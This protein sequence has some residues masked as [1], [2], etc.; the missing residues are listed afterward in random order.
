MTMSPNYFWRFFFTEFCR[1]WIQFFFPCS[2]NT[3][4]DR[5]ALCLWLFLVLLSSRHDK[6]ATTRVVVPHLSGSF[7]SWAV[8]KNMNMNETDQNLFNLFRQETCRRW[9][10]NKKPTKP[11][12]MQLS[13]KEND[14]KTSRDSTCFVLF[15]WLCA[16]RCF[17]NGGGHTRVTLDHGYFFGANFLCFTTVS[18]CTSA[19]GTVWFRGGFYCCCRCCWTINERRIDR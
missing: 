6:R 8:K 7:V 2:N 18:S 11:R 13:W 9:R 16:A 3:S 4:L 1:Q 15:L 10:W 17:W 5:T 14:Y 12:W 19:T